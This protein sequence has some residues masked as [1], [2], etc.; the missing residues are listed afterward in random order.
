MGIL[1]SAPQQCYGKS[2]AKY[3]QEPDGDYIPE[4]N[5]DDT[6]E[7]L[8]ESVLIDLSNEEDEQDKEV[9]L[10]DLHR[11]AGLHRKFH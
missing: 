2:T 8:L 9:H 7:T 6:M 11:S 3:T 1:H 5:D 10:E 4:M